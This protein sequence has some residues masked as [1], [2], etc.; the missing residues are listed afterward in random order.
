MV[1]RGVHIQMQASSSVNAAGRGGEGE[2]GRPGRG[3][4]SEDGRPAHKGSSG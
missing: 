2:D 1:I 4:E 3:G